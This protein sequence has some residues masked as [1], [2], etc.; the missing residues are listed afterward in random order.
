MTVMLSFCLSTYNCA[1]KMLIIKWPDPLNWCCC[2]RQN[3]FVCGGLVWMPYAFLIEVTML[4]MVLMTYPFLYSFLALR[5]NQPD[6]P[7]AFKIPGGMPG[8][9]TRRC[10]AQRFLKLC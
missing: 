9:Y 4:L 6:V 5:I 1:A 7:R 3:M 10:S 8:T 2:G